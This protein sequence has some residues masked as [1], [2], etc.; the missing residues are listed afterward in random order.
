MILCTERST[1]KDLDNLLYNLIFL[2]REENEGPQ[3]TPKSSLTQTLLMEDGRTES[4]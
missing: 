1:D 3:V 4:H 2:V